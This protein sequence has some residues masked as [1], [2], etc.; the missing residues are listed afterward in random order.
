M[1]EELTISGREVLIAV[2]LATA[3]Y[4]LE[5]VFFSR[6]RQAKTHK[7][8]QDRILELE[9]G[10][11]EIKTRIERLE[12]RPPVDSALDT[13]KTIHAEAVRMARSGA[14]AQELA[15]QLGISLT[16]ADLIVALQKS[17]T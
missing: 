17:E 6:R 3:V 1:F 13:Q 4:L 8:L 9:V 2:V 7:A 12:V 5:A 11:A 14:S 10:L 15:T 16:E